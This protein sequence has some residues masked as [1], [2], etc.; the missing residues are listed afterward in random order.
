MTKAIRVTEADYIA[1]AGVLSK[2]H[3][4][5]QNMSYTLFNTLLSQHRVALPDKDKLREYNMFRA[6]WMRWFE[7]QPRVIQLAFIRHIMEPTSGCSS[8]PR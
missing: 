3:S 5:M 1:L 2:L 6:C 7:Y 8:K 4:T